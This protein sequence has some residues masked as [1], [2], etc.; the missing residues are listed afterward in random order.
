MESR[1]AAPSA[2]WPLLATTIPGM[3]SVAVQEVH[4]I[5]S[6][7]A[8]SPERGR[9]ALEGGEEEVFLLNYRSR[10]LHRI[11]LVLS[12]FTVREL[13][14]IY[15]AVLGQGF[16]ELL[17]GQ[18]SFAVRADRH[19]DQGFQSMDAERTAGQAVIDAFVRR[20]KPAP[21]VRLD[22]PDVTVLLQIHGERLRVALDTTGPR[23][24]H[25]RD[26]GALSHPAPLK[27]S[28]AYGLVRL[29]GWDPEESLVDPMCGSGTVCIE[30]A[31]WANRVPNW[32]RRDLAFRRLGFLDQRA[33]REMQAEVDE[34]VTH[35]R[36]R[37]SGSD[38]SAKHALRAVENA[39]RAGAAIR[40]VREDALR[41]DLNCDR[42]VTNPPYGRRMGN[43]KRIESLYRA[44]LDRLD[45]H[46]WKRAVI[47]T[48]RPD[49][50][51]VPE[52]SKRIDIR[53]GNLSAALLILE[54]EGT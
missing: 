45:R 25:R 47:L 41:A 52:G 13:D 27:S 22:A 54:G 44:F 16:P 14:D 38:I 31:L 32:F 53:F 5:T 49:L 42:I 29:S 35:R 46:A 28:L 23:S 43:R 48:G 24:L 37:V 30:A 6:R 11:L 1:S 34:A 15:E 51:P 3:E 21:P 33:F 40:V 19:G 12:S 8:W 17:G 18:Q 26:Y 20:G 10:S 2:P 4:E 39:R 36:L 7:E 9:V 50:A